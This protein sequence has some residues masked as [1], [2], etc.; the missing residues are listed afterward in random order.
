MPKDFQGDTKY[1]PAEQ[2]PG[3]NLPGQPSPG[4]TQKTGVFTPAVPNKGQGQYKAP[5]NP[6]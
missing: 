3:G 5:D 1:N 2:K 4:G 6:Y